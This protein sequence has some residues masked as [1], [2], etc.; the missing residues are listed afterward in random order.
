LRAFKVISD[1]KGAAVSDT[2]RSL[3]LKCPGDD[4]DSGVNGVPVKEYNLLKALFSFVRSSSQLIAAK[5]RTSTV[6]EFVL[7]TANEGS[8][9]NLR[10]P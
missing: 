4:W 8:S 2:L 3:F 5:S 6:P 9:S 7:M 1:V 10:K